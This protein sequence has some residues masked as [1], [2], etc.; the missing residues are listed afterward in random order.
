MTVTTECDSPFL[1]VKPL[2]ADANEKVFEVDVAE[3]QKHVPTPEDYQASTA[4]ECLSFPE[5]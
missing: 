1:P 2:P 3:A 5:L 4:G